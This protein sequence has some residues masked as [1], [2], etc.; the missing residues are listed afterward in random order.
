MMIM[1]AGMSKRVIL[2]TNKF[3]SSSYPSDVDSDGLCNGLD[4][5]DDNEV[6]T[7]QS[8]ISPKIL[9]NGMITIMMRLETMQT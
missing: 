1:T 4:P 3:V 7:I 6:T 8:M 5:D 2:W 9:L